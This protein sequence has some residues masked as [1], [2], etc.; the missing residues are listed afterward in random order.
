[1]A[2]DRVPDLE[3]HVAAGRERTLSEVIRERRS[4]PHFEST[5]IPEADLKKILNA[6]REAPS[7]YNLQPW[8]FVVVRDADMRKK[9]REAAMGQ[10]RVE[11]AP[12]VVVACG[13]P[14]GWKKGDLDEMLRLGNQHGFPEAGNDGARKAVNGLLGGTGGEAAGISGNTHVWVNRHVMIAFTTLMWMAECLG[15]DT[16]PMEG[17][18]EDKVKQ[19]LNIPSEVRVVALLAIGR[20]K[21]NDKPYG[22]RFPSPKLIFE[23][24]W[25][26]GLDL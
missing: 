8:R 12:V 5:P 16:A 21:G 13:D 17:F 1:M 3:Q 2:T 23:D 14:Q 22:G 9:L 19:V 11:E 24:R 20:R 25:G 6:A 15:Y 10:P 26:N 4:T 7:G 18:F